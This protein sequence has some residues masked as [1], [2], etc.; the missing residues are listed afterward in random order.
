MYETG[1][2]MVKKT[3]IYTLAC[4]FSGEIKYVGKTV[5]PLKDRLSEHLADAK[6]AVNKRTNWVKSVVAKGGVPIIEAL[7]ECYEDWEEEERYW[8]AQMRAWGFRLKNMTDGGGGMMGRIVSDE[9]KKKIGDT[10]RGR[11]KPIE[12]IKKGIMTRLKNGSYA[13]TDQ[14][15]RKQSAALKGRPKSA[16][17]NKKVGEANR[18]RKMSDDFKR[19]V[20]DRMI[21]AK[22]VHLMRPV[23]Q[24]TKLGEFVMEHECSRYAAKATNILE[25][26][27]SNCLNNRSKTAGGFIW[28]YKNK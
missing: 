4:P 13:S 11:A 7:S 5:K 1:I 24:H 15:R 27:I 22:Q 8:I 16:E 2:T 17:H 10:Q 23:I 28:T 18:G 3:T 19:K 12:A 25:T 14:S 6:R 26:S 21:G 9:T 20:R